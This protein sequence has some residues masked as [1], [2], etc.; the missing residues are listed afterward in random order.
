MGL[1]RA[2]AKNHFS[3]HF[4]PQDITL[5][6]KKQELAGYFHVEN[7]DDQLFMRMFVVHP[8]HQR[9]GIGSML[10]ESVIASGREQGKSVVLEVFKINVA[11][12]NFYERH[13]FIVEGETPI[14]YVMRLAPNIAFANTVIE[15][16]RT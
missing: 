10:L 3:T 9:K 2:V 6:Y 15:R 16:V 8:H 5:V 13:R 14:S 7:R 12:K 11:A 4:D 1:G